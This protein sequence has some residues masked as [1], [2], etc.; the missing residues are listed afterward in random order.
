MKKKFLIA[1][2]WVLVIGILLSL[3]P[4]HRNISVQTTAYEYALDQKEPLRTHEVTIEGKYYYGIWRESRFDG[5]FAVSGFPHSMKESVGIQFWKQHEGLGMMYFRDH[6]GQPNATKELNQIR[7][8][9]DFSN[10]AVLLF[11]TETQDHSSQGSWDPETGHI[12]CTNAPDYAALQTQCKTLGF[13]FWEG[14]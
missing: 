14:A 9:R 3:M 2:L 12:L 5:V 13:Y 1:L 11:E 4:W 10:F 6:A 8:S 7:C